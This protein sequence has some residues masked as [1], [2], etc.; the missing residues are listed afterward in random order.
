MLHNDWDCF[1]RMR[2]RLHCLTVYQQLTVHVLIAF[3][4]MPLPEINRNTTITASD[5]ELVHGSQAL[6]V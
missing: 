5:Y 2:H 4:G 3:S 1:G 6:I